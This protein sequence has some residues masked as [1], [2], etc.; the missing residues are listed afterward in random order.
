LFPFAVEKELRLLK[1]ITSTGLD[2]IPNVLLK[3]CA[4]SLAVPLSH[5]FDI[6]FKD[7]AIKPLS[8]KIANVTP[9]HKKGPTIDPSNYRPISLL[10]GNGKYY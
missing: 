7:G 10:S 8:W 1:P 6:S 2:G 3:H 5:L 9:V 4:R